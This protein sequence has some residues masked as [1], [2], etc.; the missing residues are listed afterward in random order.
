[1]NVLFVG[2]GSSAPAWYRCALPARA[3]GAD[4]IGARGDASDLDVVNG[5]IS[6]PLQSMDDLARYDVIVLQ[7]PRGTK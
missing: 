2:L 3:L 6:G 1:M 7:Q 5:E 4:W